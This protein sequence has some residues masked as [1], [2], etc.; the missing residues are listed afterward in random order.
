MRLRRC[1]FSAW[2]SGGAMPTG[3]CFYAA[4]TV[5]RRLILASLDAAF[6]FG[7][8]AA[9]CPLGIAFMPPTPFSR[10]LILASLDAVA[11]FV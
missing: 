6:L 4:F 8:P 11:Q 1:R 3:H 2:R 7:V 5:S 10:R 9:Q